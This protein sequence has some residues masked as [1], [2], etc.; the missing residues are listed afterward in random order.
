MRMKILALAQA[1]ALALHGAPL[2]A[3]TVA[4]QG[5]AQLLPF[6]KQL[7]GALKAGLEEGPD[8][9]ID[10]CRVQAPAIAASL[11]AD[12]VRIGRTSHRLRNPANAGPAWATAVLETYLEQAGDW[13]PQVV[14]LGEGQA[15]YVEPIVTQPLCLACHGSDLA[16]PVAEALA[17]HYPEDRAT[18]FGEGDL[19]GVFWV[20]F[21]ADTAEP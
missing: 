19:R 1:L 15:G 2:A 4:E 16:P 7:M 13:A 8:S 18:G 9:A 11:S 12:D 6:K 14:A 20:S 3:D 17:K 10:A 5:A 21:T